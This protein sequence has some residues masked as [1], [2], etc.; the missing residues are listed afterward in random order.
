VRSRECH[1]DS[2]GVQPKGAGIAA[3]GIIA[4]TIATLPV[5]VV[6]VPLVAVALLATA[7]ICGRDLRSR[8][9]AGAA[10]AMELASL[11]IGVV[12]LYH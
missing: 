1:G 8:V 7:K 11:V 9:V 10:G 5:G 2:K 4:I 12:L 3:A 6:L